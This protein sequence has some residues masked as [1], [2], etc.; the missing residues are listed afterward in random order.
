MDL[1]IP[2][3]RKVEYA[4]PAWS[5][6][7]QPADLQE[8]FPSQRGSGVVGAECDDDPDRSSRLDWVIP[9]KYRPAR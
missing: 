3:V 4:A 1:R 9:T 5:E 6:V 8:R 2:E 7:L